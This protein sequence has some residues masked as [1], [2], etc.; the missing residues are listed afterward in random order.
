MD[1]DLTVPFTWSS[2]ARTRLRDIADD[3]NPIVWCT[4]CSRHHKKYFTRKDFD[5][6]IDAAAIGLNDDIIEQMLFDQMQDSTHDDGT[7]S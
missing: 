5:R 7:I 1:P 4:C 6:I 3:D 2:D